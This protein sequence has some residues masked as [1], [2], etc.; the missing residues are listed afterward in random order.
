MIFN[1]K[2]LQFINIPLLASWLTIGTD[3]YKLFAVKAN[4]FDN[5]QECT[6]FW[7]SEALRPLHQIER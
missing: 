2:S 1:V 4:S 5:I 7:N 3:P 6:R